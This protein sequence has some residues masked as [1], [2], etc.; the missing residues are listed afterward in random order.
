M[1]GPVSEVPDLCCRKF[2]SASHRG[3]SPLSSVDPCSDVYDNR[4]QQCTSSAG[5]VNASICSDSSPHS[6]LLGWWC[7]LQ[8]TEAGPICDA[9]TAQAQLDLSAHWCTFM[10]I[11]GAARAGQN[12]VVTN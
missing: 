8:V 2:P 7:C 4:L 11:V 12:E 10:E 3:S 6:S 1:T 9:E 5:L